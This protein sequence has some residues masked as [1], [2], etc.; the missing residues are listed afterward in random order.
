[1]SEKPS[2]EFRNWSL[3]IRQILMPAIACSMR[4]RVRASLRLRRFWPGVSSARLGFFSAANVHARAADNRRSPNHSA[5]WWCADIGC[6]PSQPRLCHARR[7]AESD[8][9]NLPACC[10]YWPAP[11]SCR[12]AVSFCRCNGAP[13]FHGFW[14]LPPPLHTIDD[15]I[16]R[17]RLTALMPRDLGAVALG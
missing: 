14:P 4:T 9:G 2:L 8:L 16:R 7:R 13:V 1:M 12:C 15:Q 5:R 17:F 11:G 6:L 10:G 3:V